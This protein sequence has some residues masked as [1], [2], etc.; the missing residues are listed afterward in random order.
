MYTPSGGKGLVTET[1]RGGPAKDRLAKGTEQ[2][3]S[4]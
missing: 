2:A 1:P 4:R 3:G